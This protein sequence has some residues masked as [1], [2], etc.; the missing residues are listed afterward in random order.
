MITRVLAAV[1]ISTLA[2]VA[3]SSDVQGPSGGGAPGPGGSN[4]ATNS[5]SGSTSGTASGGTS[6][7]TSG[8]TSGT[9]SGGTSGTASSSGSPVNTETWADGKMITANVDIVAGATVTIAPGAKITVSAGVSI[10]VHGTLTAAA[11]ANHAALAGTGWT[12]IVVA[13]GGT[14]S[15]VGV[16]LTNSTAGIQVNGNDVAA[17]YD[18]G[19]MT[20]GM[21]T[22]D[23]GGTFKT[24]HAALKGGGSSSVN[25]SFTATF[26]DMAA[27]DMGMSDPSAT[28]FV[29]DSKVTGVG[30]DFFVPGA[31]KLLHIEYS[32]IDGTHCPVHFSGISKF[33]LDHVTTGG[34]AA[35]SN[36]GFGLMI[37]NSDTGP[38]SIK[39]SN[40]NDPSWDQTMRTP[41]ITVDHSFIKVTTAKLGQVTITNAQSSVAGNPD[42][43]PRGTPG[44]V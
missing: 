23:V 12:G 14:M 22:V 5:S 34:T 16:D 20:G 36:S 25:G 3:C 37:Y 28:V 8:G 41:V 4:G 40:F 21:F 33:E 18:Y 26:L 27:T 30:G 11:K 35:V 15:L 32:T 31:G 9:T 39:S 2:L 10:T 29:A 6:G 24:D 17:E 42:A 19:T 7:T 43:H 38:H 1:G 44:P 13:T